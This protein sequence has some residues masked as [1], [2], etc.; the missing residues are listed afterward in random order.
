[1]ITLVVLTFNEEKHIQ[2][3]IRSVKDIVS[4]IIVVDSFSTD[5]TCEIAQNEGAEVIQRKFINQAEQLQW[6]LDNCEINTEW[7]LRLDADEYM[8][9]ELKE[10]LTRKLPELTKNEEITGIIFKLRVYFMGKWIRH[11]GYY[12]M[13]L[14]RMWKNGGA[15]VSQKQMDERM[16]LTTGTTI[17]LKNDLVDEN[18]NGLSIWTQKHNNYSTREAFERLSENQQNTKNNKQFFMKLPLFWRSFMYFV[19]RYF[20]KLGF[21]DGK[22]GLIWHF[23]QGFWYQFLIDSKIYEINLQKK[24]QDNAN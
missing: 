14:L 19:Y 1:M 9:P 13:K 8:F 16:V 10:E 24:I 11:G 2:R 5:K 6:T 18:I 4:K 22:P 12:P 7:I 3:C 17:E 15:Y 20:I 21:L 23:L